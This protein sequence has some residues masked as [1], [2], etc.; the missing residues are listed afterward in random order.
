MQ[1]SQLEAFLGVI[2]HGSFLAASRALGQRRATLQAHLEALEAEIGVELLVRTPQGAEPT[3]LGEA[4]A[5]RAREL[6]SQADALRRFGIE[7]K[8]VGQLTVA[9][10]P[11]L[12]PNI[13]VFAAQLLGFR[14][15]RT[16][17][18]FL[19]CSAEEALS[20]PEVDFIGQFK[21]ELP[22][23][24]YRTYVNHRYPVRLLASPEYLNTHGRPAS[25]EDL[26]QHTL[27]A[28]TGYRSEWGRLWP[29]TDGT[30]FAIEPAV[31]SN[32]THVVRAL[33][34]AGMGIAFV[35]DATQVRGSLLGD[36]LEPVLDGIVGDEARARILIPDRAVDLP[37]VRSIVHLVRELGLDQHKLPVL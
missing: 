21:D 17:L 4:F 35:A 32:D 14:M 7:P 36:D 31:E 12:P 18:R 23:G 3:R 22:R 10:E 6:L 1:L 2:E 25:V 9:I 11:G 24:A 30:T 15:D 20:N 28:W 26:R 16:R 37:A 33:A 13:F 5:E 34:N 27:L 19:I 29:K 8:P